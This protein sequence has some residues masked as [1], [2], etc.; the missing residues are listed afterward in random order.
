MAVR[1]H[2]STGTRWKASR[3]GQRLVSPE[4]SAGLSLP[5]V[6]VGIGGGLIGAA[7]LAGM[8][9]GTWG[10]WDDVAASWSPMRAV[11]PAGPTDRDRWRDAVERAKGW[12]GDLSALDF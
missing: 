3:L 11:E 12:F 2:S 7:Y 4:L 1:L 8:A 9:I 10:S 5:V 6:V